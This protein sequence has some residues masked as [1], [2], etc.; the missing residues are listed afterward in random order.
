MKTNIKS[1]DI[2]ITF[3]CNDCNYEESC[4]ASEA[5]YNG[6]PLCPKFY[7]GPPLCP[8]CNYDNEMEISHFYIEE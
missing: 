4:S 6:P 5:I 2:D 1:D 8:K 3:V 7:N